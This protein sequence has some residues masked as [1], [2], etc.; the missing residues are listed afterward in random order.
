MSLHKDIYIF[1]HNCDRFG[2][3][4]NKCTM[5]TYVKTE[6]LMYI[7]IWINKNIFVICLHFYHIQD[8]KR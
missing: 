8:T 1:F 7:L 3:W 5:F 6:F 2:W 4:K